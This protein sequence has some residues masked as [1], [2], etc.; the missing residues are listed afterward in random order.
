MLQSTS[1]SYGRSF[2]RL[3]PQRCR[4]FALP[5]RVLSEQR[6]ISAFVMLP[7]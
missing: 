1:L 6:L 5:K 2:L 3:C 4:S 7:Q